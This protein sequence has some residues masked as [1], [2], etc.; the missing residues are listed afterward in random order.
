MP[1]SL[2][3]DAEVHSPT[4]DDNKANNTASVEVLSSSTVVRPPFFP[5]VTRDIVERA[6]FGA[7]AGDPV[8][9]N[10]PDGRSLTYSLTGRCSGWFQV[11]SDGQIVLG[12]GRTLD[13]D[14]QSAFHLTLN[15]SDG[16]NDSGA[17]D[18]SAD[19]ST[20]VTINVIDTP[21]NAVTPTVNF[22]F[23]LG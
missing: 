20:P 7:H 19:D 6:V 4:V 16:V 1:K 8:A 22:S 9:A 18:T 17:A 12:A 10:N 11:R 21:H 13:Y 15:V 14:E 23:N 2:T 5:G 3:V